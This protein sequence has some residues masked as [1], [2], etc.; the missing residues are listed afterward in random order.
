VNIFQKVKDKFTKENPQSYNVDP[1]DKLPQYIDAQKI[2]ALWGKVDFPKRAIIFK[3]EN[4]TF[5][6]ETQYFSFDKYELAWI[7]SEERF[8]HIYPDFE[9]AKKELFSNYTWVKDCKQI[10]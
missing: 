10:I 4:G 5:E 9:T 2:V 3:R 7:S 8:N 1:K 6:I